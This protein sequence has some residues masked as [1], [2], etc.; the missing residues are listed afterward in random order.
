MHFLLYLIP[1]TRALATPTT[2]IRFQSRQGMI[3]YLLRCL[4]LTLHMR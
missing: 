3:L 4:W 2:S 1:G